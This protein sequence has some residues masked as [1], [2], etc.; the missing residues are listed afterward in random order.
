MRFRI[1]GPLEVA[2]DQ[3]RRVELGGPTRRA[4]LAILLVRANEVVSTDRLIEALWSGRPPASAAKSLQVHVSR[5]RR[6]FRDLEPG[7]GE[8]LATQLAGYLL[9]VEHDE[10][11]SERFE[12]M[13][14]DA[15]SLIEAGSFEFAAHTL[16]EALKL[17]RG[18]PLSDF[19][20][21][22]FAQAEIARLSE[23]YLAAVEQLV[24]AEL[25]LGREGLVIADLERRVREHPYRERLRSQLWWR[26]TG[27]DGRPTHLRST[28]TAA[29]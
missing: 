16:R 29:P 6:A 17:W 9:R 23:L 1:L 3:D 22:S 15:G 12:R 4:A 7:G 20:Y 18:G 8:R 5:L 27:P 21:E 13:L 28:V 2:D 10:L 25:A 26:C 24:E 11:D 14:A 19:E